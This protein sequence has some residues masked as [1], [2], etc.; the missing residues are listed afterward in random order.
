MVRGLRV[1]YTNILE[2]QSCIKKF[3]R[4]KFKI[5]HFKSQKQNLRNKSEPAAH[6]CESYLASF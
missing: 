2:E 6:E 3:V 1:R 4:S 5:S